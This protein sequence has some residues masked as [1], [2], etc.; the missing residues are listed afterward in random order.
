MELWSNAINWFEIPVTDFDRAVKF[1][2]GIFDYEM[3]V[4]QMGPNMMGF[5]LHQQ[6]KGIGG[7]IVQGPGY[8]PSSDGAKVYLNGGSDLNVVLDRVTN[9]GGSVIVGKTE[10]SPDIG[11]FAIIEDTEGNHVALHSMG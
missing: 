6:G 8:V 4:N 3:P 10:I 9:N 5:F 1:Y 7:S 11:H 2:S